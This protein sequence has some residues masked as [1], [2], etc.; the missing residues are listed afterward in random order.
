[1][2]RG[3]C[4]VPNQVCSADWAEGVEGVGRPGQAA[5]EHADAQAVEIER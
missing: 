3:A 4:R 2:E 5:G 1:M